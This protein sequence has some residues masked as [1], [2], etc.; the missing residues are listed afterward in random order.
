MSADRRTD[1]KE[2]QVRLLAFALFQIRTL[3]AAYVCSTDG[4]PGAIPA[5]GATRAAAALAYALHNPALAIMA[6]ESFDLDRSLKEIERIDRLF[7][8]NMMANLDRAVPHL[9]RNAR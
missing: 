1:N 3:L 2:D 5:D 8:E 6:G 9:R 4:E 7:G